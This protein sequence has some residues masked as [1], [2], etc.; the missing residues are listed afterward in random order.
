MS[1][2]TM[3]MEAVSPRERA[4]LYLQA[5]QGVKYF[6]MGK[7]EKRVKTGV[8][9]IIPEVQRTS[10]LVES[11]E[12]YETMID[13]MGSEKARQ[14]MEKLRPVAYDSL[15]VVQWG[16][17][18]ADFALSASLIFAPAIIR[19]RLPAAGPVRNVGEFFT[20][21]WYGR[22]LGV[23]G[24]ARF[25]PIEWATAKVTQVGALATRPVVDAILGGGTPPKAEQAPAPAA[26]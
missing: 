22:A 3:N 18:A 7:G 17:R 6:E 11:V 12:A 25:R 4:V 26:A 5:R 23:I 19:D 14:V 10:P 24:L 16:A 13:K 15:R 9:P 1:E 2:Q 8:M 21:R 20:R